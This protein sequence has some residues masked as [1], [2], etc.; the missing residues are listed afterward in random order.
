MFIFLLK[1]QYELDTGVNTQAG[2]PSGKYDGKIYKMPPMTRNYNDIW[3]TQNVN[4]KVQKTH[5]R[6]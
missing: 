5:T 6:V 1:H 3:R 2:V 4:I